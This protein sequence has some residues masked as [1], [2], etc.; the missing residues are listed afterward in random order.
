MSNYQIEID[1]KSP[2]EGDPAMVFRIKESPQ[3][4]R[5][6]IK[7]KTESGR[8][9]EDV[10]DEVVSGVYGDAVTIKTPATRAVNVILVE[11]IL[12]MER[13]LREGSS[14][15]DDSHLPVDAWRD[16]THQFFNKVMRDYEA[17]HPGDGLYTWGPRPMTTEGQLA[18]V[19]PFFA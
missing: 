5:Q 13:W 3:L 6:D 9:I 16:D 8:S 2:G 18:R 17:L 12:A 10:L 7:I 15:N 4:A 11:V 14:Y 1:N 19:A